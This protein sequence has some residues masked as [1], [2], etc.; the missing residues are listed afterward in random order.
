MTVEE[1]EHECKKYDCSN[2]PYK[3][4]CNRLTVFLNGISPEAL[5]EIANVELN[6]IELD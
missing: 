3:K 2:C 1:L 4:Q 6:D 5:L